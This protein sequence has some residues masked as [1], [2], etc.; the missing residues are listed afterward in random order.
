MIARVFITLKSGVLDPAGKAVASSLHALVF[1]EVTDARV[2]KYIE[3]HLPDGNAATARARV[4]A[5]CDKLLAN[6]VIENC[7]VEMP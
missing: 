5:M 1:P 2:G 7:R 6:T 4:E 3:I